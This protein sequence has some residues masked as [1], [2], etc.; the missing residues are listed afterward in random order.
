MQDVTVGKKIHISDIEKAYIAGFLD[1]D[2]TVMATIE[3]HGEKK[4]GFRVRI[5]M[6]FSQHRDNV[7][8]LH[9]I[10]KIIGSGSLSLAGSKGV[11]KLT[12]KDRS[13]LIPLLGV[14][15]PFVRVKKVQ[16]QIARKI[17][18]KKIKTFED[19]KRVAHLSDELSGHN[20]KSR[21]RRIN[22]SHMIESSPVTTEV[23]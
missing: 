3:R 6:D 7:A 18:A 22:T 23:A 2:G 8:V 5:A 20:L 10:R 19:L 11:F 17:L 12:I 9:Y 21:S 14:L 15:E 4:F 1:G 13:V 16:I